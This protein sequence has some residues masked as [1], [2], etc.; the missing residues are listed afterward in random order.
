MTRA[1]SHPYVY[2]VRTEDKQGSV[3]GEGLYETPQAIVSMVRRN[4]RMKSGDIRIREILRTHTTADKQAVLQT[5]QSNPS[6]LSW[7]P[8]VPPS[9]RGSLPA[10][11]AQPVIP[12]ATRKRRSRKAAQPP[13]P[14]PS[15]AAVVAQLTATVQAVKEE[16]EKAGEPAVTVVEEKPSGDVEM[17]DIKVPEEKGRAV[18]V[19]KTASIYVSEATRRLLS[20]AIDLAGQ[21][22]EIPINIRLVGTTGTGK[23]TLA[24]AIGRGLGRNVEVFNAAVMRDRGQWFGSYVADPETRGFK[25]MEGAFV[26]AIEKPDTVVVI[27]EINR[28]DPKVMNTLLPLLDDQRS[29]YYSEGDRWIRAEPSVVF[30][31]TMNEG[32]EYAGTDLLDRAL[33]DRFITVRMDPL[34][35]KELTKV[36]QKKEGI[37]KEQADKIADLSDVL[38]DRHDVHMSYRSAIYLAK[39]LERGIHPVEAVAAAIPVAAD[40]AESLRMEAANTFGTTQPPEMNIIEFFFGAPERKPTPATPRQPRQKQIDMAGSR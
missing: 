22:R 2:L 33:A 13:P 4:A 32:D 35:G 28:A 15:K 25:W 37:D 30:I 16:K 17:E 20:E 5:M 9:L 11:A 34:R 7:T 23:T 27:D 18:D 29:V 8:F 12:A 14:T 10:Q 6:S 24:K 26:K 38:R 19:P 36:L 39:L 31:A 1:W 40:F 21:E 3:V